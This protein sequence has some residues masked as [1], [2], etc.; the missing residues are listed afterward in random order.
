MFRELAPALAQAAYVVTPDLPG[1]GES[2]PMPG[3]T[4]AAMGDAIVELLHHLE[5]G[6][7]FIY[8]HDWGAPVGLHVA[9]QLARGG[10]VTN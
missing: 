9:I 5:V 1:H 7:R 2:D 3:V 8:L 6:P 10:A 4:F